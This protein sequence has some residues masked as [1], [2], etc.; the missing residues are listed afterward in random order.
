[1]LDFNV[2]RK[3]EFNLCFRLSGIGLAVGFGKSMSLVIKN[4]LK[5]FLVPVA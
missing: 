1:M 5:L 3:I 4:I 2:L